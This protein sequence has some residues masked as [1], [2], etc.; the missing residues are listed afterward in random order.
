[1]RIRC[2]EK[3]GKLILVP[4][5]FMALLC[6]WGIGAGNLLLAGPIEP[7]RPIKL[8]NSSSLTTYPIVKFNGVAAEVA[9]SSTSEIKAKV[10]VGATTGPISVETSDGSLRLSAADFEVIT[11]TPAPFD[12]KARSS[13]GNI[14]VSWTPPIAEGI[15]G[16]NIYRASSEGGTYSLIQ[17]GVTDAF[18][19]DESASL[20]I[21]TTYYYKVSA[22]YGGKESDKSESASAMFGTI[23]LWIPNVNG[24]QEKGTG[25]ALGATASL[26]VPVNIENA[27][28]LTMGAVQIYIDYDSTILKPSSVDKTILSYEYEWEFSEPSA[29]T[30]KISVKNAVNKPLR[31]VGT[32]FNVVFE[33]LDSASDGKTTDFKFHGQAHATLPSSVKTPEGKAIS[34]NTSDG[35]L[36][37]QLKYR[38][39]DVTGDAKVQ[40]N[41]S[42]NAFVYSTGFAEP[43]EGPLAGGDIDGDSVIMAND[44]GLILYYVVNKD[45]P[46]LKDIKVFQKTRIVDLGTEANFQLSIDNFQLEQRTEDGG[47]TA[48]DNS[49][50]SIVNGQLETATQSAKSAKRY[51]EVPLYVSTLNDM[52]SSEFSLVYPARILKASKFTLDKKLKKD[53]DARAEFRKKGLAVVSLAYKKK[54]KAPVNNKRTQI[55]VLKFE[56]VASKAA[57]GEINF[58]KVNLYDRFGR[59]FVRSDL[60]MKIERKGIKFTVKGKKGKALSAL[61]SSSITFSPKS[62]KPGDVVT[63]TGDF[64]VAAGTDAFDMGDITWTTTASA[65]SANNGNKYSGV[66]PPKGAASTFWGTD[67]YT[68]D[69]SLCSAAVHMGLITYADGGRITIVVKEGMSSY[70][71]T[72]RNGVT[73]NSYGT[74]GA[75]FTFTDPAVNK[76]TVTQLGLISWSSS[77]ASYRGRNGDKFWGICPEN[78]TAWT[79]WGI[80]PY[81]DDSSVCTAAVHAGRIT[82]AAGGNVVYE[83][84][85][86]LPSYGTSTQNGISTLSYGSWSGSYIFVDLP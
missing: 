71:S 85:G 18:Y 43:G 36:K 77:A 38:K 72:T 86:G 54:G 24:A 83:I 39:G 19:L 27:D 13:V 68:S 1:M 57:D 60:K 67:T 42:S 47:R 53:F 52:N 33:I 32:L 65:Y 70:A 14:E 21:G 35:A 74:W 16:C 20:V 2:S 11:P 79:V 8:K 51:I 34:L 7:T 82:M 64:G 69:S 23:S 15:S 5:I 41:D 62:G 58:S 66:C 50:S 73:S 26:Q 81:T 61:A 45:W 49:Q 80:G 76:V 3:L 40:A 55:G 56:V 48:E 37:I 78:G 6:L 30:V 84:Q 17:S 9:S 44:A 31:G 63:I 75:S 4:A 25:K 46:S 59:D 22:A 12:V 10:P 29:G 28:K